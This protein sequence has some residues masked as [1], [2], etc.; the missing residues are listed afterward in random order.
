MSPFLSAY[1]PLSLALIAAL[2]TKSVVSQNFKATFG[3][4]P[5]PFKI[6]VDPDFIEQTVLNASLTRYAIDIE[7]PALLD[8]PPRHNVT[9]VRDYWVNQYNWFDVQDQLNQRYKQFTTT[10]T[11]EPNPN[12][13]DP[14][15]LHFVHHRSDRTDAIPLL[16][17]HGWPGSFMEVDNVLDGLLNPPGA[18]SPAFHV[19]VPSIPGFAF[20]PAPKKPGFALREAAN[21]F[22]ALMQQ[23]NYTQ[24]VIQGGDFG[25]SI[26]RVL[27]GD[28][29]SSVVSMLS[30]FWLIPPNTTDILRYEE[31][32]TTADENTIIESLNTFSTQLSGYRLEQETQPLQV[33]I[34]MTDSPVGN[35][36]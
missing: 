36:M 25:G 32:L 9:T 16:F 3:S 33:A 35:A 17:L 29:P 31:G 21:T 10:V 23:L 5:A 13:T 27:A 26:G 6:D 2:S 15:P 12:L 22:N 20:S 28:Y 1:G 14:V 11:L 7:V 8:G 30:N 24:F 18:S 19:V 34:D 4:S